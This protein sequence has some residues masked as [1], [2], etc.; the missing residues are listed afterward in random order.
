MIR[1]KLLK[2]FH[3]LS[4]FLSFTVAPRII[5]SNRTFVSLFALMKLSL[6]YC[7]MKYRIMCCIYCCFYFIPFNIIKTNKLLL[8]VSPLRKRH[9]M[10]RVPDVRKPF[11]VWSDTKLAP[12]FT[13]W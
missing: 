2:L 3:S 12:S 4:L 6:L 9:S 8:H 7:Y 5:E 13:L 10:N 11:G 1:C